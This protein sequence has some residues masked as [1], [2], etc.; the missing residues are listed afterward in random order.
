MARYDQGN[1]LVPAQVEGFPLDYYCD[2]FLAEQAALLRCVE[3]IDRTGQRG[4]KYVILTDSLSNVASLGSAGVRDSREEGIMRHLRSACRRGV[5]VEL[6]FVRGHNGVAGNIEADRACSALTSKS[7]LYTFW[8]PMPAQVAR[9]YLHGGCKGDAAA[10]LQDAEA[11]SATIQH[12]SRCCGTLVRRGRIME[13]GWRRNAVL[14]RAGDYEAGR[15]VEI[16]YNQM[17]LGVNTFARGFRWDVDSPDADLCAQCGEATASIEHVLY[18]CVAH[19]AERP[20]FEAAVATARAEKIQEARDKAALCAAERGMALGDWLPP[21][22]AKWGE[23]GVVGEFP[24]PVVAFIEN[25]NLWVHSL[26]GGQRRPLG[27]P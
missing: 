21:V 23:L 8:R 9:A 7:G 1:A 12:Y 13:R 14:D 10:V 20:A 26:A 24:G 11:G 5:S 6:R 4:E 3:R 22:V 17:R 27:S 15:L 16:A 19:A 2:S 25:C 18:S